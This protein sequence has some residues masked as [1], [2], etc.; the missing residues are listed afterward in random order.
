[1]SRDAEVVTAIA[2]H[3]GEMQASLVARVGAVITAARQATDYFDAVAALQM[4][5]ARDVVPH[6]RAEEDVL[7]A[8]ATDPQLRPLVAG[9]VFE[10]ETLLALTDDLGRASNPA[11]AAAIARAIQE[12]FVGHVRRE[13]ELLLPALAQNP[14]V[15]LAGLL[16]QMQ[17]RFATY[18]ESGAT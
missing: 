10:H 16:P 14:A 5:L 11:D 4:M 17:Q 7:Y 2:A 8:A 12:V 18:Q 3:H 1:M 13:N 6:A 9:M 15:D